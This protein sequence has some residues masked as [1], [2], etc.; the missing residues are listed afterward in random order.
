MEGGT[1]R[2]KI[3]KRTVDA[4]K[5]GKRDSFIWDTD[6]KGFGLKMTPA[7]KKI[8]IFQFRKPRKKT[9]VRMTIG[10]YGEPFGENGPPLTADKAR[11]EAEKHRGDVNRSVYPDEKKKQLAQDAKASITVSELCDLYLEAA[12]TLIIPKKKRPKKAKSVTPSGEIS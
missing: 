5:H 4:A 1:M 11:K 10:E 7:G 2:A 3:T 9:P 8:F 12:P 6:V